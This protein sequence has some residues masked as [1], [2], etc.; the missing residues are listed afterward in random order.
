MRAP[1][2]LLSL[3]NPEL[4]PDETEVWLELEVEG[5]DRADL[6]IQIADIGDYVSYLIYISDF[7]AQHRS[8]SDEPPAIMSRQEW[9]PISVTGLGFAPGRT[10]DETILHVQF[11][12]FS[13][14]LALDSSKIAELGRGFAQMASLLS[15]S[16]KPQ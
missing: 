10:P 7:V 5:G 4:S 8:K 9:S 3:A 14:G 13:L 12:G 11:S 6:G 2:K 16:G 15:A 1:R